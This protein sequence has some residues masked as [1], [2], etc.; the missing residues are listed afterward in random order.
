MEKFKDIIPMRKGGNE[1]SPFMNAYEV[2]ALFQNNNP[3]KAIE[4]IKRC[5]G[6]IITTGYNTFWEFIPSSGN[7][8]EE[9]TSLCHLWSTGPSYIIP[10]YIL[11]IRPIEPGFKKIIIN[12]EFFIFT[13]LK[14]VIPSPLGD[15]K[16]NFFRENQF[17]NLKLTTPEK[18][19]SILLI[20]LKDK[21]QKT[22]MKKE[23]KIWR[24]NK[25]YHPVFSEKN[26]FIEMLL[27]ESGEYSF[28]FLYQ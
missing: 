19:E 16:I 9:Y 20:P 8:P 1:I 2:E 10:S 18:V 25:E 24:F 17:Y 22:L 5:W 12:P 26:K 21:K 27:K 28:K 14:G 7:I 4:L 6:S 3:E 15:V 23:L 11:G 13:E